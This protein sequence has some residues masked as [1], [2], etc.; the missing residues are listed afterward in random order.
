MY[1]G[2]SVGAIEIQPLGS[3]TAEVI[4]ILHHQTLRIFILRFLKQFFIKIPM[5]S[6]TLC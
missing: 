2:A 6:M 3:E 1:R 5:L 4:A